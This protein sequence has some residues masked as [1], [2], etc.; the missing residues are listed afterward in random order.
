MANNEREAKE[1]QIKE[2]LVNKYPEAAK[3]NQERVDEQIRQEEL[4]EL[5]RL[6]AKY[7]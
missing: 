5:A 4:K 3:A 2:Q 7:H 6:Q 1:T